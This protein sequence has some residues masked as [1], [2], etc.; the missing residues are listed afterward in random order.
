M[1]ARSDSTPAFKDAYARLLAS[2]IFHEFDAA[3][4]VDFVYSEAIA[5]GATR[6]RARNDPDA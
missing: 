1:A 4:R 2:G 6:L 3:L 5:R